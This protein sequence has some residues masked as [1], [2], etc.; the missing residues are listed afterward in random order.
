MPFEKG[1]T[2]GNGRPKGSKNKANSMLDALSNTD[3]TPEKM[4]IVTWQAALDDDDVQTAAKLV[5]RVLQL[6][7][8]MPA[9]EM[10]EPPEQANRDYIRIIQ[11]DIEKNSE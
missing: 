8:S 11:N 1:N 5:D 3:F 6:C 10:P 4:L 7:F 2:Y 9:Q